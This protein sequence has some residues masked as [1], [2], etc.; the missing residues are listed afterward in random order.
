MHRLKE[1]IFKNQQYQ[2]NLQGHSFE[3]LCRQATAKTLREPSDT[4]NAEVLRCVVF[5]ISLVMYGQKLPSNAAEERGFR[6]S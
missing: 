1:T 3:N 6:Q 4:A 5:Y 2:T